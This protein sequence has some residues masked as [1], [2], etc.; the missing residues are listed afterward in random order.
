[1]QMRHIGI[2]AIAIADSFQKKKRNYHGNKIA[3]ILTMFVRQKT[4]GLI[5]QPNQL[6]I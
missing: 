6:V 1:M 4:E 2:V 3:K 5:K